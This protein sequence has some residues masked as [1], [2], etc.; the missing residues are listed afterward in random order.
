MAYFDIDRRNASG[1]LPGG[2]NVSGSIGFP[3]GEKAVSEYQ[4][5]GFP[6]V[7]GSSA[8]D[9]SVHEIKFPTMTQWVMV[10]NTSNAVLKFGFTAFGVANNNYFSL[11]TTTDSGKLDVRTKSIFVKTGGTNK[12]YTVMAGLTAIP[13]G[14]I[15]DLSANA[16]WGV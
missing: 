15:A 3:P 4:V 1:E 12:A 13:T 7:S 6:F 5:A 9:T 2:G 10:S 16:Y 14:S 11:N 8:T